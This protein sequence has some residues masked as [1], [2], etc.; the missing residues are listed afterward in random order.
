MT[1]TREYVKPNDRTF[2]AAAGLSIGA[3]V[4]I[5]FSRFAYALLLPPMRQALDWNY[6]QAGAMNTANAVGYIV[7]AV[8]A[9]WLARQFGLAGAFR[10]NLIVSTAALAVTG[11]T[12]DLS[13]L[14]AIRTIGGVSTAV[15]F[16]LG[17]GLAGSMGSD[18]S[19]RS[20]SVSVGIYMA[21][22]SLGIVLSGLVV[23]AVIG[24]GADGWHDGWFA[25]GFMAILGLPFAWIASRNVARPMKRAAITL[26][27]QEFRWLAPTFIGYGLFGCGYVGYMTFIIDFL[28]NRGSA[29]DAASFWVVLGVASVISTPLWGRTLG[30]MDGGRGPAMISA[31]AMLGTLVVIARP[32]PVAAYASALLFG[33]SF[34]A[35][36]AA[37]TI[38]ARQQLRVTSFTAGVALLTV[39]FALG[40]AVGPV[41][42]GAVTDY[43]GDVSAGLW[44][45]PALLGLGA[46]LA[47]LQKP[48]TQGYF[49]S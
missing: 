45:S 8:I 11:A 48:A 19:A 26:S 17:A 16:I 39:S 38:V 1:D 31:V 34:M 15:T 18:G 7:G 33:G 40:Q 21:G 36:P 9:A 4:A 5:A 27:L 10:I 37:I 35:A 2:L 46:I 49:G 12:S 6:V 20:N 42:A 28:Q 13:V 23:P 30:G 24:S 14:L 29:H 44:I 41:L 43:F 25:L 32:G 3:V 47:L 22:G